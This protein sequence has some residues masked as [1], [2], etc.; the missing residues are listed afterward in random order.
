VRVNPAS[1]LL[2][3]EVARSQLVLDVVRVEEASGAR[4]R[5]L[6]AKVF[7]RLASLEGDWAD[8]WRHFVRRA[9]AVT[10]TPFSRAARSS[11]TLS[12][13]LERAMRHDLGVLQALHDIDG[14]AI[15]RRLSGDDGE[16]PSWTSLGTRKATGD[17]EDALVESDWGTLVE[18][19]WAHFRAHSAGPI[20]EYRAFRYGV[21]GL[22]PIAQPDPVRL[23]DLIGYEQQQRVLVENTEILA[24]GRRANNALLYGPRGTGKSSTVKALV[25]E[26]TSCGVRL[27]QIDKNDLGLFGGAVDLA[28]HRPEKFVFFIDDLSYELGE[29][30][31][32]HL[33]GLLE[34]GLEVRPDNVVVY[35]TS[36]RR[37]LVDERFGDRDEAGEPVHIGDLYQHKLSLSDRFGVRQ[38]FPA[39][40]QPAYLAIVKGLAERKGLEATEELE[41]EAIRWSIRHNGFSPRS[42]QHFIDHV[43]GRGSLDV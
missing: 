11:G 21:E 27:V 40:D 20:G 18:T 39:V 24:R 7:A 2:Y 26:F 35:A 34:G 25:N 23:S 29:T 31:Y 41:A 5:T 9:V 6:Y 36:N 43:S 32:G 37:H 30:E 1:L 3:R 28:R 12:V 10:E 22:Q 19:L 8:P 14:D 4:A 33:K 13:G 16:L 17:L 42:A 15:A 38:A